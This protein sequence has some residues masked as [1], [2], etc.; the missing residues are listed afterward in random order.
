MPEMI[1]EFEVYCSCGNGI[2]SNASVKL[3]K[4]G[5]I[6]TIGPC[7]KCIE[8]AKEDGY[9]EGYGKGYSEG[10]ETAESSSQSLEAQ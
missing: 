1:V 7:E 10:Q 6:V 5:N 3:T 2:C 4:Y 9:D 8:A